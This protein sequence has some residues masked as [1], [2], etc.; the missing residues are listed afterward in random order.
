MELTRIAVINKHYSNGGLYSKIWIFKADFR[1][2]ALKNNNSNKK[3]NIS[4]CLP[5]NIRHS[6]I[7][8]KISSSIK[9]NVL[10][11]C[12]L[13]NSEH[14]RATVLVFINTSLPFSQAN[15]TTAGMLIC[16]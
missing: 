3:L 9:P 5:Q 16:S 2:S 1:D 15:I 12:F 4:C 6:K 7:L 11:N 8:Y 10:K 13:R 14:R